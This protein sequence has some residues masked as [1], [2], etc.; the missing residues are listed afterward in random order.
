MSEGRDGMG[1]PGR[2]AHGSE[3]ATRIRGSGGKQLPMTKRVGLSVA[4]VLAVS[5]LVGSALDDVVQFGQYTLR[6]AS[7]LKCASARGRPYTSALLSYDGESWR[8]LPDVL[9]DSGADTSFFPAWVAEQL[10]I[11]LSQCPQGTAS[12]VGGTTTTYEAEIYIALVHM[13]GAEVDVDGYI[14]GNG[15]VPFLP[16]VLVAF[17]DGDSATFI[18]GR[19]D[20]FD[21]FDFDFTSDTL[22]IRVAR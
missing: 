1:D 13:G 8:M 4:L 18:L 14:L 10:G 15:G 17:V 22:T 3:G 2:R 5:L 12:G 9:L 6:E 16:T 7:A 21:L 19:T 20:A 11:D